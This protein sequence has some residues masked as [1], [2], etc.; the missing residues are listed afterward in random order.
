MSST[1]I[2]QSDSIDS[3]SP[4]FRFLQARN[5]PNPPAPNFPNLH[6]IARHVSHANEILQV[7]EHTLDRLVQAQTYW[8]TEYYDGNSRFVKRN[9]MVCLQNKQDLLFLAKEIH[10]LKTRSASLSERLQNEINL[11]NISESVLFS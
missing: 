9:R 2:V 4:M 5:N 8:R 1:R 3:N 7:A 10:S 6:D 11:V